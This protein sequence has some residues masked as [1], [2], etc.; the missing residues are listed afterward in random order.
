M[1]LVIGASVALATAGCRDYYYEAQAYFANTTRE[2]VTVRLL[3]LEAEVSCASLSGR[4]GEALAHRELFGNGKAYEV[5]PGEALPLSLSNEADGASRGKCAVLLQMLGQPDRVVAWPMGLSAETEGTLA[6]LKDEEFRRV[7]VRLEGAGAIQGL[8]IGDALEVTPLPLVSSVGA[9]PRTSAPSF[10]W[11]GLAS[12]ESGVRLW[13]RDSLPD[14]CLSVEL[15]PSRDE[16]TPLYLCLP[17]WAFPFEVDDMLSVT[18][19]ELAVPASSYDGRGSQARHL[20]LVSE[21]PPRQL[22]LW[23]NASPT[24][25][26]NV[27][28]SSTSGGGYR[29]PCGGY[30]APL[31]VKLPQEGTTLTVG[32]VLE[33]KTT[34]YRRLTLLG[35]ADDMLVAPDDCGDDYGALGPRLDLL[36]LEEWENT[37]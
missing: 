11:S 36:T 9:E 32:A 28:A 26:S 37:P 10:G 1:T 4:S 2:P 18:A 14:G 5:G 29:T 16:A 7:S 13:K 22:E 23:L 35:R 17:D 30:A 6:P 3:E 25:P 8:A 15:G 20:R 24:S 34:G 31:S 33:R 19:E 27:R 21:S 12:S